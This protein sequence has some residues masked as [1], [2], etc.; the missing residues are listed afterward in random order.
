M[1]RSGPLLLY[2]SS[3]ITTLHFGVPASTKAPCGIRSSVCG[4][5]AETASSAQSEEHRQTYLASLSFQ[6]NEVH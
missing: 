1:C 2:T 3:E 6:L 5:S 4:S